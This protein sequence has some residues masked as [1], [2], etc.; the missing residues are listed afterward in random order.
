MCVLRIFFLLQTHS[1]QSFFLKVSLLEGKLREN[2]SQLTEALLKL[3]E[4]QK[5]FSQLQESASM[6]A[7][8][9][10]FHTLARHFQTLFLFKQIVIPLFRPAT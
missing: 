5:N 8:N 7:Q 4:T 3:Q 2:E 1:V 6:F 9:F 10:N